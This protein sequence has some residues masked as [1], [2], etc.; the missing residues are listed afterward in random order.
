MRYE[1][2]DQFLSKAECDEL[3]IMATNRLQSSTTVN[4]ISGAYQVDD[5]RKSD[6]MFFSLGENQLVD[7]I[8]KRIAEYTKTEIEN[9]ES[10][11]VVKYEPGGYFKPHWDDF[12][13]NFPGNLPQIER[14]GQRVVT[15]L[16]Y[17][18][19]VEEGGET[20]FHKLDLT[21]KPKTGRAIVWWNL[22]EDGVRDATTYHEGKP[23]R[24]GNKYIATKWIRNKK[25]T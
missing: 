16:M 6:Q 14:G 21:V 4:P 25:F 13:P 20:Y 10:M 15:T 22:T 11:Q 1:I 17:L 18:N 2:L 8:E 23:L 3:I 12:D 9:G 24:A 19:D 5:F 7:I